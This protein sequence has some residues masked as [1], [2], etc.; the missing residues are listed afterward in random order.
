MLLRL[1][2]IRLGEPDV[3]VHA[4]VEAIADVEG[5]EQLIDRLL[6]AKSWVEVLQPPDHFIEVRLPNVHSS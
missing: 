6:D 5:L 1:G 2:R 4:A 3:S